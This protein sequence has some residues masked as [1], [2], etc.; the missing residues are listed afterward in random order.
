MFQLKFNN[1][2]NFILCIINFYII[3]KVNLINKTYLTKPL[4]FYFIL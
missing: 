2:D 4:N 3:K 1:L